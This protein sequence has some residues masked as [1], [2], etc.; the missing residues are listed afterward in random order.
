M[1]SFCPVTRLSNRQ[2]SR[3]PL[4]SGVFDDGDSVP[5]GEVDALE[6]RAHVQREVARPGP[7]RSGANA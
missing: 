2:P 7:R 5:A 1:P 6:V 4:P 3:Q